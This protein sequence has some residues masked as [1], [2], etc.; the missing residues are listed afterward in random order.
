MPKYGT[1]VRGDKQNTAYEERK[2]K[3][4]IT[5]EWSEMYRMRYIA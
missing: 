4:K 2:H 3:I 1:E 5:E